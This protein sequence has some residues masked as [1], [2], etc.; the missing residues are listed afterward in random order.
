[1]F[2]ETISYFMKKLFTYL[3][4]LALFCSV[5][6][7]PAQLSVSPLGGSQQ[8]GSL[9][10][11]VGITISN[12]T[13]TCDTLAA[14]TFVGTASN[15]GINAGLALTTGNIFDLG[16]PNASGSTSGLLSAPGDPDMDVLTTQSTFDA[17]ILE[18][19]FVPVGDTLLFN[20]VFGS[21]E[22]PEFVNS[23]FNDGFAMWLS[24][25]GYPVASNV[26]LLPGTTTPVTVNNVNAALNTN[27]YIDNGDGMSLPQAADPTVI[28]FDGF[29]VNMTS[30][31]TVVPGGSYHLKIGVA[32]AGDGAFDTG[33]FLQAGSFRTS[34]AA[35][36]ALLP[37]R[38]ALQLFPNPS[39]GR[40][41]AVLTHGA[42]DQR[43]EVVDAQGRVLRAGDWSQ[44][45]AAGASRS[46]SFDG[47]ELPAG[48][49]R[50]VVAGEGS[51]SR[52]FVV[53]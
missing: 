11:G 43:W 30:I 24:G 23:F 33:V 3:L 9:L 22:Y 7:L 39:E 8:L 26:A 53:Q 6:T 13:V 40:F 35:V 21:E 17:C 14:A 12:V 1:M 5:T 52:S 25:P 49:Y 4:T 36:N 50:F 2:D 18:F 44:A 19:D 10:A 28:Q 45:D 32:D 29:T 27:F 34:G 41:Q 20:Y 46:L 16:G 37:Q 42:A 48:L 31:S 38:A 47:S 15:V 51:L